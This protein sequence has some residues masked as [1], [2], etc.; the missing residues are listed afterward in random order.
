MT[1]KEQKYPT[2]YVFTVERPKF[3]KGLKIRYPKRKEL[4]LNAPNKERAAV[5][6]HKLCIIFGWDLDTVMYWGEK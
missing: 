4:I 2:N 3:H 1:S 6:M 5:D